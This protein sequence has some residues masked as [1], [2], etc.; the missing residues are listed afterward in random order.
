MEGFLADLN[1]HWNQRPFAWAEED[2]GRES[3]LRLPARARVL[4]LAPHPDDP[5][6]VAITCRLLAHAGCDLGYA[7]ASVSPA[8]VTDDY[9]LALAPGGPLNLAETKAAI[10]KTEQ[11]LAAR[12]FGLSE[13]RIFFLGLAESERGGLSDSLENRDRI[14]HHL[15]CMQPDIVILPVGND[16]NRTH[17]WVHRVFRQCAAPLAAARHRPLVA[18]YNED[19]KTTGIRRDLFVLFGE[20]GAGWKAALLRLHDSQQQRNLRLRQAGFDERI[21][22]LNRRGYGRWL[23][24]GDLP[25]EDPGYAEVFELEL[26]G[27]G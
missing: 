8:G 6:S 17:A 1:R 9:A 7:I 15:E 26:F 10:R 20:R 3:N 2:G 16:A 11:L 22:E 4:V 25:P 14:R 27:P 12:R 5:E 13:D 18:L 19:P 24:A 21:L 23:E